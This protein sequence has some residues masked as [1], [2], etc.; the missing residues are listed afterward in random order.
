MR[1]ELA[2]TIRRS[3]CTDPRFIGII[4]ILAV[5]CTRPAGAT[6]QQLLAASQTKNA[7]VTIVGRQGLKLS[8]GIRWKLIGNELTPVITTSA[9]A[10]GNPNQTVTVNLRRENGA[11]QLSFPAIV[12]HGT[13]GQA[14]LRGSVAFLVI[15][16]GWKDEAKKRV[17]LN[18]IEKNV[19]K[20]VPTRDLDRHPPEP[21]ESLV[22]TMSC[23]LEGSTQFGYTG[24]AYPHAGTLFTAMPN[25]PGGEGALVYGIDVNGNP[26]YYGFRL[27]GTRA[28]DRTG[29]LVDFLNADPGNVYYGNRADQLGEQ[30]GILEPS[31][32]ANKPPLSSLMAAAAAQVKNSS[33]A[34]TNANGTRMSGT[35]RWYLSNGAPKPF[36]VTTTATLVPSVN[37]TITVRMPPQNGSQLSFPARVYVAPG[38]GPA[39]V[40]KQN[41]CFLEPD[42]TKMSA[43]ELA[44][45]LAYLKQNVPAN[46]PTAGFS[47]A[48]PPR[49]PQRLFSICGGIN[50]NIMFGVVGHPD[51]LFGQD[52]TGLEPSPS[53]PKRFQA[54]MPGSPMDEG[55]P[56]FMVDQLGNVFWAGIKERGFFARDSSRFAVDYMNR[57]SAF[58]RYGTEITGIARQFDLVDPGMMAS[59]SQT[60][61]DPVARLL[62]VAKASVSLIPGPGA[63]G[64]AGTFRWKTIG[65]VMQLVIYITNH[66]ITDPK[67]IIEVE[68]YRKDRGVPVRLNAVVFAASKK[69]DLA[70]L[71]LKSDTP[72]A[73]RQYLHGLVP[74]IPSRNV[75]AQP[76]LEGLDLVGIG[77]PLNQMHTARVTNVAHPNRTDVFF[78]S[79]PDAPV[80]VE[81]S[82][83]VT[84]GDS[85]M[86]LY[87][88]DGNGVV[89][90]AGLAYLGL[91]AVDSQMNGID[92][93]NVG[94]FFVRVDTCDRVAARF[95]IH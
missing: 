74:R 3:A 69:H 83:G 67:A 30:F 27:A 78:G 20:S 33:V 77:S 7:A 36:V 21:G 55:S 48:D 10:L 16:P 62:L 41:L 47:D 91:S 25:S 53:A 85:G 43:A 82:G 5:A 93:L 51:R 4:A 49:V 45:V 38:Q 72:E 28:V 29:A 80:I 31:R 58:F 61:A 86:G 54:D 39:L 95:G 32:I 1:R 94:T 11:A 12:H 88:V 14:F 8:G 35:L 2:A 42:P 92:G 64:G 6:D 76:L 9:D 56:G 40:P 59:A 23:G 70:Y 79:D 68:A 18:F 65:G 75:E 71:V 44:A 37:S 81:A 22:S 17:V 89:S 57:A 13:R 60:A 46:I 24:Q 19:P 63:G 50:G 15:D 34:L 52:A 26:I 84:G 90:F 87:A 66:Q 73:I